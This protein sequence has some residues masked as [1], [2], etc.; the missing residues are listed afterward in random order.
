I[1]LD[2][3]VFAPESDF[4]VPTN[5]LRIQLPRVG[6]STRAEF[7]ITP[8][9]EGWCRLRVAIYYRNALLQSVAVEGYAT[10]GRVPPEVIPTIRRTL[11]WAASTDLLLLE[12]LPA[13]SF[14]LFSNNSPDG[15]H[16]IGVFSDRGDKGLP[17]RSGQMRSF[18]A[19]DLTK[20]VED[21]RRV[22]QQVHGKKKAYLY[23]KGGPQD[24]AVLDFGSKAL[25]E[26]AKKG[27]SIY[28]YLFLAP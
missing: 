12:E 19:I 21:L 17:L 8:R 27:Y 2:V 9:R 22:I 28:D 15:T 1:Q 23:P 6:P 25:I 7:S 24:A 5:K 26:L 11:D 3:V 4:A 14:T 20:R 16:W 18:D 13:P 10:T